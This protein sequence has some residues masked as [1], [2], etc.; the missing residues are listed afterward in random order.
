MKKSEIGKLASKATREQFGD[1]IAKHTRVTAD[2]VTQ[3][4]P[5]PKDREE[6]SRLIDVVV[7]AADEE[8]QKARL[9]QNTSKVS[10]AV[11][12]LLKRLALG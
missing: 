3:L 5:E 9:V 12:T 8:D 1:E 4:F 6:L 2:E 11:V 10:G 7:N